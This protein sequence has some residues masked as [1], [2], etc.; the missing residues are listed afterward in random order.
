MNITQKHSKKNTSIICHQIHFIWNLLYKGEKNATE[1]PRRGLNES[2]G[3]PHQG[4]WKCK[5]QGPHWDKWKVRPPL[6]QMKKDT[7]D[8]W[9]PPGKMKAWRRR[10]RQS[11]TQL[12]AKK[13]HKTI[14]QGEGRCGRP[15]TLNEKC[16][17]IKGFIR[18]CKMTARREGK[19]K[20]LGRK[21][22]MRTHSRDAKP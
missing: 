14:A 15:S 4:K 22:G 7:R 5:S 21:G 19:K 11:V 9:P 20:K 18:I 2:E 10:E 13:A 3:G 17:F 12:I 6:G 16:C 1:S 8:R